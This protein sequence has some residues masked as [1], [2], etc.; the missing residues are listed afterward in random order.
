VLT[1]PGKDKI[2]GVTM[3]GTHAGDLIAEFVAAMKNK[4]GL[5]AILQT[6]HIY[7][8]LVEVNKSV[9]GNWRKAHVPEKALGFLEKY[10]AWKR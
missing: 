6:I 4:R 5:G 10:F 3:V 2:L 9:A 7:P 1:V 8:T